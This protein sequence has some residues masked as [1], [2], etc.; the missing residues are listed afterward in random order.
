MDEEVRQLLEEAFTRATDTL[1]ENREG[2]DRLVEALIEY[3]VV[4]GEKV[5]ELLG[6]EEK[7][8]AL[9][10]EPE[11]MAPSE[12]GETAGEGETSAGEDTGPLPRKKTQPA[13]TD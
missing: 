11:K 8:A 6:M 4:S 2:L 7:K 5:L 13:T 1:E 10:I 3:E 12:E 9:G